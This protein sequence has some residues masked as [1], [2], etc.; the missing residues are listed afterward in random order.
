[1][2]QPISRR[3][4][5]RAGGSRRLRPGQ[6][7]SPVRRRPR[8]AP[9]CQTE[10]TRAPHRESGDERGEERREGRGAGPA[11]GPRGGGGEGATHGRRPAGRSQRGGSHRR[12][13]DSREPRAGAGA[14]PGPEPAPKPEP[15]APKR[16]PFP[17]VPPDSP[18]AKIELGMRHD[19][20]L[21][22]LGS[23][24]R[25]IDHQTAKAWIPF[26]DGPDADLRDWIYAG[27]GRVVFSLYKGAL[28]V[29]DVIYDPHQ[30]K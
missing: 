27:R 9:A 25:K 6:R 17:G 5:R 2:S 7:S 12:G 16:Q 26:Y 24:D 23:P 18:L 22:I 8:E 19:E 10:S 1:M 4:S 20:V 13:S 15:A 21:A 3:S 28:E 14:G 29:I 11:P 30:G